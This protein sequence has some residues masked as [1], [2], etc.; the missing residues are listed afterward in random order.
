M[1]PSGPSR[2]EAMALKRRLGKTI[3]PKPTLLVIT[4]AFISSSRFSSGVFFYRASLLDL[5]SSTQN[6]SQ[7]SPFLTPAPP[8]PS[9]PFTRRRLTPHLV[10]YFV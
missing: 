5:R 2:V 4:P 7:S 9:A 10:Q 3:K 6:D 1:L 8:L